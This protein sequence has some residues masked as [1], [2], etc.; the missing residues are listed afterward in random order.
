MI[1][2]MQTLKSNIFDKIDEQEF[3]VIDNFLPD[4]QAIELC[5]WLISAGQQWV[6]NPAT[7]VLNDFYEQKAIDDN[8][9][10]YLQF[11][12]N[13]IKYNDDQFKE[14]QDENKIS[15]HDTPENIEKIFYVVEEFNKRFNLDKIK[16]FR[17][18]ANLLTQYQNNK[19]EYYDTPHIDWD[20]PHHVLLYY[21]NDSDGDTILFKD[22][23]IWKRISP[24]KNRLLMFNHKVLHASSHP[25]ESV[26]RVVLNYNIQKV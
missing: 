1:Q 2:Q 18:K 8:C 26:A 19:K 14:F 6:F 12:K 7:C 4:N 17:A 20:F 13:F 23:K 10:E 3:I 24:K 22:R 5:D 21:V 9:R 25:I 16:I 11:G 15:I